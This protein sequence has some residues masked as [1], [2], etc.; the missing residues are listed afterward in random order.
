M[1][2]EGMDAGEREYTNLDADRQQIT[3]ELDN[4]GMEQEQYEEINEEF[5]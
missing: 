5:R 3:Q 1:V 2:E 4:L